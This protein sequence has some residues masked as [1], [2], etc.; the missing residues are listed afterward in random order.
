MLRDKL[1]V[2]VKPKI[3]NAEIS[4]LI[5]SKTSNLPYSSIVKLFESTIDVVNIEM[6]PIILVRKIRIGAE[7][8]LFN[9]MRYC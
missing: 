2:S 6:A 1:I 4:K 5:F 9:L 8:I 7:I 3:E